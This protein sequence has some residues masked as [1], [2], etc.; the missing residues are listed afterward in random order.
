[1][2]TLRLPG[3]LTGIDTNTLISQLMAIER[4]S[5]NVYAP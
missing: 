2:S 4:R 1:M 3:L 5:L